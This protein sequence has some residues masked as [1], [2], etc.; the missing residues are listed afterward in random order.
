MEDLIKQAFLHLDGIGPQVEE[1]RYHLENSEGQIIRPPLWS[2]TIKPGDSVVMRMWPV[3]EAHQDLRL[4]PPFPGRL[5]QEPPPIIRASR[6]ASPPRWQADLPHSAPMPPGM[7]PMPPGVPPLSEARKQA[8]TNVEARHRHDGAHR[9]DYEA[10]RPKEN[11]GFSSGTKRNKKDGKDKHQHSKPRVAKPRDERDPENSDKSDD[12]GD[13]D[14][15]LGL[16]DLEGADEIAVK[17]V[18]AL[19]ETWTNVAG[20]T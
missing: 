19:L 15:E 11:S 8:R 7:P 4:G 12:V 17:D 3:N 9:Q 10:R 5:M 1:G 6:P 2:T 16:D 14:K 18:D 13:I 20:D